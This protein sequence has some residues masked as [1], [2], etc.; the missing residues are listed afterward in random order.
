MAEETP[1][2][3][4]LVVPDDS[5]YLGV[6]VAA[7]EGLALRAG[8]DKDEVA[9]LRDHLEEAFAA[10]FGKGPAGSSVMLRYEV[11]DGF[12]GL[13]LLDGN[14]TRRGVTS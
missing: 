5:R 8:V 13:R 1:D 4:T 14:G 12:L 9:A 6:A 3:L 10:R 11:G 7:V 2:V